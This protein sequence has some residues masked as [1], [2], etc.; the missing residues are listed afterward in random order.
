MNLRYIE[1]KLDRNTSMSVYSKFTFLIRYFLEEKLIDISHS[2]IEHRARQ[3]AGP[4]GPKP[5]ESGPGPG[6]N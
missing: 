6:F 4:G 5:M 3:R 1:N 2:L